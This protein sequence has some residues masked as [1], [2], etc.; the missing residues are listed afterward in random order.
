MPRKRKKT[1]RCSWILTNSDMCP[2]FG[3]FYL[4]PG[5]YKISQ[6]KYACDLHIQKFLGY[7]WI[8]A[9]KT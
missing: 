7:G 9:K 5:T 4:A 8:I 3:K 1:R 6:F 2:L